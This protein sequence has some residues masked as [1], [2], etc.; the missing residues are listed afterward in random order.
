MV[1][2]EGSAPP[3]SGCR[4]DVMLFHHRA[5]IGCRGWICT[6]ISAFKGRCPTIRRPGI[7]I[8][9]V[10]RLGRPASELG[11]SRHRYRRSAAV[12]GRSKPGVFWVRG[13]ITGAPCFSRWC[14]R[15]RAHSCIIL[16]PDPRSSVKMRPSELCLDQGVSTGVMQPS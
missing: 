13:K 12:P 10:Q 3:I 1:A 15:G 11:A 9:N 5:E 4:P 14:A 6:S 2:R 7:E 16:V 8:E